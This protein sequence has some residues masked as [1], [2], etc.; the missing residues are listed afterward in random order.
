MRIQLYGTVNGSSIELDEDPGFPPGSRV[1]V[2]ITPLPLP[3]EERRR[4][5][6]E[7]CGA[8]KDDEEIARIFAEIERERETRT[9]RPV[10]DLDPPGEAGGAV[11][12]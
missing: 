5:I 11:G 7:T 12:A 6:M 2:E 10:P 1:T 9:V 4:R 3:L 8:W